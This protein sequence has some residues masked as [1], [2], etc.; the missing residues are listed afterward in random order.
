MGI[1]FAGPPV[2]HFGVRSGTN[3]TDNQVGDSVDLLVVT[4]GSGRLGKDF[5]REE[6]GAERSTQ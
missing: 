6:T 2:V 4:C 5:G 1:E 3:R